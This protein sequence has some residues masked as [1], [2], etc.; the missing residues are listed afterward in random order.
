MKKILLTRIFLL[1]FIAFASYAL[2]NNAMAESITSAQDVNLSAQH[3][4]NAAAGRDIELNNVTVTGKLS[5]G[6]NITC[7]GCSVS[8]QIS[9]GR[10]VSLAQCSDVFGIASG[11]NADLS[12]VKIL[13]HIAS[14]NNIKLTESSV[15]NGLSA[16]NEVLAQNSTIN[17]ELSL[18]GHY[19]RLDH[20]T[21]G[22]IRFNDDNQLT[23]QNDQND[24]NV[25]RGSVNG[26]VRTSVKSN[27]TISR[28][29]SSYVSVGHSGLS[30]VNGYTIKSSTDTADQTGQTTVI[31]PDQVIYVN[32]AKVSGNGPKTY[33]QYQSE[34]PGAPTVNGPGWRDADTQK[35]SAS[36]DKNAKNA[37][38]TPVNVLDVMNNSVINGQVVFESG[39]GKVRVY[40]G[41]QFNGK[42]VNGVVEKVDKTT[43]PLA[44]AQ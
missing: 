22:D 16:G 35:A 28:H 7:Q 37:A 36:T 27:V 31:T 20:A 10:D 44:T 29:G 33:A 14:G 42:V 4:D 17:G 38:K 13:N 41:S 21:T 2:H 6:R 8:G 32:G 15:E 40:K 23:S 43:E 39:Y 11:R 1:L 24:G 30:S 18:G 5:A 25:V 19:L 34:H 3:L 12:Q 26:T 9:A